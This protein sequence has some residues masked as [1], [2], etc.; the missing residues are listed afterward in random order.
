M[1]TRITLLGSGAMATACSI[2]LAEQP[3]QQVTIWAR[4]P[5]EARD[6]IENRENSRLLPGVKLHPSVK[7]YHDVA[8]AID[9][10]E[11]YVAAIP[12]KF[13]RSALTE[14][15]GHLRSETPV[16]TVIK[17]L[18]EATFQRPSEIIADVIGTRLVAA[19]CGPSHAEEVA[20]RLPASVV[21]ACPDEGFARRVQGMFN[22]DRFRVYTNRDIIGVELAGALKNVIAIAAGICDGLGYGDN[23]KS[24]LI[25]RGLVEMTRFGVSLGADAL[26]FRGLAGMGDLVTTCFSRHS[27][28]RGVGERL[29]RGDRLEQIVAEMSAVAEGVTTTRSI[30]AL[31]VNKQIEMPITAAVHAV[32]FE[33]MSPLEATTSLMERAPGDESL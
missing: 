26:T 22:T 20:R 8:Q 25:T 23:A 14:I 15:R 30:H 29:G 16:V 32:L 27:R 19:L 6:L 9:G 28:N 12:S 21:A 33:G 31:A 2:L 10:A 17:G 18:E 11:V 1:T 3:E 4:D 7:V 5:G 13:L 24:A